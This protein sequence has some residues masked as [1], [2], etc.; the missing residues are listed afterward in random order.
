MNMNPEQQ[1]FEALRRLLKLKR[2]EKPPPRYFNDF[3]SQ[4]LARI[5]AGS[6]EARDGAADSLAR[7]ATWFDRLFAGFQNKPIYTGALG[8][9][10]CLLLVWGAIYSD[11]NPPAPPSI[12][13]AGRTV[14]PA[15]STEFTPALG[16]G[17][18]AGDSMLGSSSTN[19]LPVRAGSIFDLIQPPNAKL[20]TLTLGEK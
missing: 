14:Q 5:R 10:A 9:V 2:Y 8:A 7:P 20:S 16:F 4:V 17:S 12:D 11:L 15:S 13:L 3:S 18:V 1:D 6:P 19:P